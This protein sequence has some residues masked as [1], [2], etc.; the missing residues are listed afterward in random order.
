MP[1]SRNDCIDPVIVAAQIVTALQTIVSRNVDPLKGAVVSV[2]AI[3]V[4]E[5]YNVI[6]QTCRMKGTA[7]ALEAG[8]RDLAER[9]IVEIAGHI[10][11]ALGAK[12][13]ARYHRGYPVTKNHAREAAICAEWRA[14]VAGEENVAADADPVMGGEDFAFMLEARPGAFVFIGNGDSAG[15]AQSGL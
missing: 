5:A 10:G 15:P 1:P 12:V 11:H 14:I 9:R 8:M 13:T 4:G 6:A 7:R 2:T 3:E